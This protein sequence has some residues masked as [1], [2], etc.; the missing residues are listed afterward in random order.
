VRES[1]PDQL[2]DP[3]FDPRIERFLCHVTDC[4]D[5]E[6]AEVYP[7]NPEAFEQA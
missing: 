6:L 3:S 5:G 1:E 2:G 4:T 7:C